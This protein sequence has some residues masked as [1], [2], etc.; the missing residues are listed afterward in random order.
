MKKIKLN[1]LKVESFVTSINK[2]DE[3]HLKGGSK[4]ELEHSIICLT[5]ILD[6]NDEAFN[7]SCP[8]AILGTHMNPCAASVTG[9]A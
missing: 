1:K 3:L 8:S 4:T 9:C 7:D 6:P 5:I 2:Y